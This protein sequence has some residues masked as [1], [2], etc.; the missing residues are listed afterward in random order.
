MVKIAKPLIKEEMV[1][2][3]EAFKY[4]EPEKEIISRS[5][6]EC[7]IALCDQ[8]FLTYGEEGWKSKTDECLKNVECYFEDTRQ[9]FERTMAWLH[10]HA[11]SRS[12]GLGTKLPWDEQ[13][14]VES[15]SDSTIYMAYYTVAHYLQGD[16]YGSTPGALRIKP[17]QMT[18]EVWD[19]IYFKS[20]AYPS[21]STLP[22]D[23]LET[24]RREFQYWYP[25][26][27]RSSGKDLVQNHLT[28]WLYNH[29]AVWSD[30]PE[31]WPRSVRANGHLLMDGEKMSKSLGNIISLAQGVQI[32]SADGMRLALADAGDVLEDA[33]F[34]T[35]QANAGILRLH[36]FAEWVTEIV[37]QLP[38][39]RTGPTSSQLYDRIFANDI[40]R[41]LSQTDVHFGN[42]MFREGLKTG[43]YEFL[44]ARDRY[45]ELAAAGLGM[46]RGLVERYLRA[47]IIILTPI[48]PHMCDYL[49]REV[50]GESSSVVG[51]AWPEAGPVD[52]SLT[53]ASEHLMECVHDF[54]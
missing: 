54:R 14:L 16:I 12:F 25:V 4:Q 52:D 34:N 17:E 22:K 18:H 20:A 27:L 23:T 31:M 15:L 30:E 8:W 49:W 46:H 6:D 36:T 48:C 5:G 42:T 53:K 3:G 9:A 11:C 41:A 35:K 39:M 1:A 43:F 26:D 28:Y 33:N 47:Q 51:A 40:N 29:T 38:T 44:S 10:E 21:K 13:W 37:A 24:L 2:C 7:V 19:Y 45:K 32:Y 50:M